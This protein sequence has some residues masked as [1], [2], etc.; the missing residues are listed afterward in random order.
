MLEEERLDRLISHHLSQQLD[1]QLGRA[2][3]K[4]EAD[5]VGQPARPNPWPRRLIGLAMS[6]AACLMLAWGWQT[7]HRSVQKVGSN[8]PPQI[9]Q[10]EQSP[11][12]VPVSES[13]SWRTID[14]GV[15]GVQDDV[16]IR[17]LRNQV[18]QYVEWYDPQRKATVEMTVPREEIVLIGLPS[19]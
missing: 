2:V 14:D 7:L 5:V 4:F 17:Q 10:V 8:N 1:P 18:L 16:P 19:H 12:L 6:A 13:I 3:F 9:V 15:I 11:E